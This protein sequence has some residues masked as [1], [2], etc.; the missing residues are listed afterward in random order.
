MRGRGRCISW[1]GLHGCMLRMWLHVPPFTAGESSGRPS[2]MARESCP[3][4]PTSPAIARGLWQ[5]QRTPL[6]PIDRPQPGKIVS[7]AVRARG[8][9]PRVCRRA[10]RAN[11]SEQDDI[12]RCERFGT[13]Q[14]INDARLGRMTPPDRSTRSA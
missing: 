8:T 1:K 14:K 3:P 9:G 6:S 12:E 2:A 10:R 11:H 13:R 5:A 7:L 4:G